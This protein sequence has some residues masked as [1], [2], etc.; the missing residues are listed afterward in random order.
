MTARE[1]M[2]CALQ[3]GKP[4]RLPATIHQW[5]PYHL[6]QYMGGASAL[7][8]FI[9]CGLDAS[10]SEFPL[11]EPESA[12]WRVECTVTHSMVHG[13]AQTHRHTTIQTPGGTLT[14]A[15]SANAITAW[16]TEHLIKQP[17]D[18]ALL[19]RYRPIPALDREA[20]V[21]ARAELGEH[22]ILRG[23][24]WGMQGGCWQ[25][26]CE[27][28]GTEALILAT[29]DDPDWV[30]ALLSALLEQKL[31]FVERSL[32]GL[33]FDLI[34]T[35]G[36]AGSNTVISPALHEEFCLPYDRKLH[37]AV[38]AAGFPV[39]YHT[40]GG[41][42]KLTGLIPQNGCQVSETLSPAGVGGDIAGEASARKLFAEL[43]GQVALI[44]GMDQFNILEQ[45]TPAQVE[46]E[47]LRLFDWFGREGGY[48]LSASDHFFHAPPEN[49]R[50]MAEAA[51]RCTY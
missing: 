48:I 38:H 28:Y 33:P 22:G 51:R 24:V 37:D 7:Q 15:S 20:V 43:H 50:A 30:H 35:G 39:V 6:R 46:A 14:T 31:R 32:P 2:L 34:E 12:D 44:G 18:I 36:G 47:V 29:F 27:L 1:R 16:V 3:G 41:M 19:A 8:A 13:E 11:I 45:G 9:A 4:D 23:F 42:T 26:A 5:Q 17:E 40:C 25:D 10:I 21:R 49:L